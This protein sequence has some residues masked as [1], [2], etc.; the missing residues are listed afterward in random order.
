MALSIT[1][2]EKVAGF[3]VAAAA[4]AVV[5]FLLVN[6]ITNRTRYKGAFATTLDHYLGSRQECLWP[7]PIQLPAH[8]DAGNS[9]QTAQFDALVDAGL[10][11]RSSAA[12]ER[13]G[14]REANSSEY[15]LSDIGRLN[16]TADPAQPN[17]G[18]FCYGNMQVSSVNSYRRVSYS[19]SKAFDVH[20]RDSVMLPAWAQVPQVQ[21]AFPLLVAKSH[22]ERDSATLVRRGNAWRVQSSTSPGQLAGY[23][24]PNKQGQIS[25]AG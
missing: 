15:T 13:R 1:K 9:A 2:T 3:I 17:H 19:G 4:V 21:K 6:G 14:R 22:G 7:D 16:W 24:G 18:N 10:L 5:A 20:Y 11:D 25:K 8:V 12:R 23:A